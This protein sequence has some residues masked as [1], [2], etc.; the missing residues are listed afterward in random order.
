MPKH[1]QNRFDS[2][3][4]ID[5]AGLK[6]IAMFTMLIDHLYHVI[7]NAGIWM[8]C[9][10]RLAFPIFAFQVAEGIRKTHDRKQYIKRLW[11]FAFLSEI[12]FDLF[13][14]GVPFNPSY[15]NVIFTLAMAAT[16]IALM[17]RM[18]DAISRPTFFATTALLIGCANGL[19]ADYGWRGILIVILFYVCTPECRWLKRKYQT[20]VL[21]SALVL[22][23]TVGQHAVL[24]A[25]SPGPIGSIRVQSMAI[26]A[27]IPIALYNGQKGR[28]G[29]VMQKCTYAFYPLHMLL[30]YLIREVL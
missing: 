27:L 26:Y 5:A 13:T 25:A 17:N 12:P 6:L 8:R 15:Q 14:S 16:I 30:L 20:P 2:F 21:L 4:G 10:G 18:Y 9:V 24:N 3:K 7:P 22:I 29:S 11:L 19:S 1:I 23:N 28:Y